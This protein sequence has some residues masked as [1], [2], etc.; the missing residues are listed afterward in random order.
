MKKVVILAIFVVLF[1]GVA[2]L[3]FYGQWRERT[4][5]LYYSGTIEATESNLAFQVNGRVQRVLVDDGQQAEKGQLLA[6]LD[7]AEFESRRAQAEANVRQAQE[8][9]GKLRALLSLY[10]ETLPADVSRARANVAALRSRVH[11]L[12]SGH[13]TQEVAQA[14]RSFE[15]A[16]LT[17]ENAKKDKIRYD[18]L[19]AK[20][21]VSEKERDVM[22]LRYETALKNYQKAKEEL[23]LFTEGFRK[24]SI[25]AARAKLAEG[26]AVLRQTKSNL[27]KITIAE[28]D[29]K[30]AMAR[31]EA[32]KAALSL[33]DT[34]LKY[35]QLRAPFNGIITSRDIEPGEVVTPGRE[36]ISIADLSEVDLKV[37]VG[38][39]EIGRVKPGQK[40]SV[41]TD[42]FPD[43][44]YE[45]HVSY[46]SPEAEF[47]PKIIQT[48]KE[49]VK[50]VYLVK[51]TLP[52]PALELKSGMPADAW[53]E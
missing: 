32:A 22:Q 10:N 42:T 44:T 5:E 36:V 47:T 13:R 40:V 8:N 28:Q 29:V 45:G 26:L 50:L 37:F 46:I 30:A 35:T 3:V 39:E 6:E 49:R 9:L 41:K 48:H 33:A 20:K 2:A 4:A 25:E 17:M 1:V 14:R 43:K 16:R 53:F 23:S 15:A 27:Q 52:N 38:E 21:I 18:K 19:Y 31:V 51:V 11:E 7:R 24:E 12:E 34:Q